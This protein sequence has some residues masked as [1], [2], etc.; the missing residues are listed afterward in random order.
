MS[1]RLAFLPDSSDGKMIISGSQYSERL[2]FLSE[3]LTVGLQSESVDFKEKKADGGNSV[4]EIP[5]YRTSRKW[6][7]ETFVFVG[8][9]S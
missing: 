8:H 9:L 3:T 2:A 1:E 4:G 6:H 7:K 5:S